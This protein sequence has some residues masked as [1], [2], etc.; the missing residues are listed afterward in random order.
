MR[1]SAAAH[2]LALA[3]QDA[4]RFSAA[5]LRRPLRP[6]QATLARAIAHAALT[7]SGQIITSIWPRQSG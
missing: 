5:V 7:R 4:P 2:A 3:L 6:Y 1:A